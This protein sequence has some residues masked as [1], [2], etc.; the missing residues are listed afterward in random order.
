MSTERTISIKTLILDCWRV[1]YEVTFAGK[2]RKRVFAGEKWRIQQPGWSLAFFNGL[3]PAGRGA[4]RGI[5]DGMPANLRCCWASDR[6]C[7][8]NGQG[9][10]VK[11]IVDGE[12]NRCQLFCVISFFHPGRVGEHIL[13]R[14]RVDLLPTWLFRAIGLGPS[15]WD[16]D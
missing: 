8:T 3:L 16:S 14:P 7:S 10:V 9:E 12:L 11:V 1:G 4:I 2:Q 6:D 5:A 13:R 15:L